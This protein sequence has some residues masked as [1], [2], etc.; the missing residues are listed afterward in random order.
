LFENPKTVF[1]QRRGHAKGK[2]KDMKRVKL[3]NIILKFQ[4]RAIV[5]EANLP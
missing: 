2:A 4:F 1:S 3:E 5:R